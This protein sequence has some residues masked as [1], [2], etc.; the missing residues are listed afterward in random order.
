MFQVSKPYGNV[1]VPPVILS[2]ACDCVGDQEHPCG[3]ES[4]CVNRTLSIECSSSAC[5]A[6][7][8]CENQRFTKRQY[9]KINSFRT[10]EKGWGLRSCEKIK[11]VVKITYFAT[12]T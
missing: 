4:S 1:T 11:Q 6:G 7:D 5:P 12:D 10:E 3:E 9:P 2:A 8:K